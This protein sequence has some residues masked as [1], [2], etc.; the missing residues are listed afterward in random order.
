MRS[1]ACRSQRDNGI[2]ASGALEHYLIT[3]GLALDL[4]VKQTT[5]HSLGFAH[6]ASS[7]FQDGKAPV[8]DRPR[9]P[10]GMP[11]CRRRPLSW[12]RQTM[13]MQWIAAGRAL[14]RANPGWPGSD[15]GGGSGP[16]AARRHPLVLT[17]ALCLTGTAIC[18]GLGGQEARPRKTEFVLAFES[19]TPRLL[20]RCRPPLPHPPASLS[21]CAACDDARRCKIWHACGLQ[22]QLSITLKMAT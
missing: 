10:P 2:L 6:P 14:P 22:K 1:L 18:N 15:A 9:A 16:V 12:A 21:A 4:L 5:T 3:P 7:P 17:V 20:Q 19:S 8:S 13:V 11:S